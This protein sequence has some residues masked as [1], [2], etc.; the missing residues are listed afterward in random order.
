[1]RPYLAGYMPVLRADTKEMSC[2]KGSVL[3]KRAV[4][5]MY[6]EVWTLGVSGMRTFVVIFFT[7]HFSVFSL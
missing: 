1:M 5:E 7:A 2:F 6:L 4:E 3:V